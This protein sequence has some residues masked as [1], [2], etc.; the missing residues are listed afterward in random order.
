[1]TWQTS[2][3][4]NLIVFQSINI[5]SFIPA[6]IL[7]LFL[8]VYY[9]RLSEYLH[10]SNIFGRLSLY[11]NLKPLPLE[12]ADFLDGIRCYDYGFED[13]V[14]GQVEKVLTKGITFNLNKHFNG[15][16]MLEN[17]LKIAFVTTMQFHE[18][19]SVAL[20]VNNKLN[21]NSV[22]FIHTNLS[23]YLA[24]EN[25][26]IV[27]DQFHHILFPVADFERLLLKCK[28]T[29][30][31]KML[32]PSKARP[33][34]LPECNQSLPPLQTTAIIYHVS[35]NYG[36]MF[37]KLHYFSSELKSKLHLSQVACLVLNRNEMIPKTLINDSSPVLLDFFPIYRLKDAALSILF[38]LFKLHNIRS[39]NEACGL[40][41]LANF[42]YKYRA[43]CNALQ[44][45][46]NLRNAIIDYDILYPKEL[47]LAFESSNI[48]TIALQERGSTSF[49]SFY[50][51]IVDTYLF[52][53]GL[54]FEYGIKNKSI[55]CRLPVNFGQWRNSLFFSKELPNFYELSYIGFGE[56]EIRDFSTV[57]CCLGW[58]TD[59]ENSSTSPLLSLKSSLALYSQLKSI[60]E[61]FNNSA[62]I[63]RMKLLSDYDMRIICDYFAGMDNVFL[64]DEYSKMNA[65]YSLCKK[66]DVIVS[67]Q[68][69]L[70][71]ECLAIGKKV[72]LINST[73]N[74]K[75]ICTD[76]YPLDFHFAAA[77]DLDQLI[78]L[79]SRCMQNDVELTGQ[80]M[81]LREKLMSD[82]DLAVD[83][84]IPDSLEKY[85]Q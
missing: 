25:G 1:M 28:Q 17:K 11:F 75:N 78:N 41:F 44:N 38:I 31:S 64:S 8:D 2:R 19:G 65:S 36:R 84:V 7:G 33:Q 20:Y 16:S 52:S 67:V 24:R 73:H 68:T 83:N 47:A 82:F 26:T 3:R 61:K 57:I 49:G 42:L 62:V 76:I 13:T 39:L 4:K 10:Q 50:G 29:I 63:L 5:F 74:C 54:Y 79:V 56:K 80:Y 53:G 81:M 77:G 35:I 45:Y 66:A 51:V 72:V 70:A 12:D 48:R 40:L 59:Q 9:L 55:A 60:A 27:A 14:Y 18:V 30:L 71:E 15:V 46:P 22:Y 85:L 43:W 6:F 58:F 21:P 69:S 23:S 32:M 37:R 34:V